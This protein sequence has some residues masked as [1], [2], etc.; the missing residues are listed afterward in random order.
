MKT[1]E[2]MLTSVGLVLGLN[3]CEADT[4]YLQNPEIPTQEMY[5]PLACRAENCDLVSTLELK[6]G[7]SNDVSREV[8]TLNGKD[9]KVSLSCGTFALDEPSN[10]N[11]VTLCLNINGEDVGMY[12]G[13]TINGNQLKE[14][15]AGEC[16]KL[17][18]GTQVMLLSAD[19]E[20]IDGHSKWTGEYCLQ[21][22][23]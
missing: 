16:A 17:K 8:R 23:Q 18:D 7:D 2:K 20:R 6:F 12:K 15:A 9:Y 14:L 11:Y 19:H 3:A 5:N 10:K 21:D 4:L 1:L 13:F 22:G